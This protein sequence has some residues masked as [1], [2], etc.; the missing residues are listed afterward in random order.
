MLLD[1]KI[2]SYEDQVWVDIVLMDIGSIIFGRPW[3]YDHNVQIE[4]R[5][6]IHSFMF[7]G[8]RI[9][10]KPYMKNI[11]PSKLLNQP[12]DTLSAKKNPSKQVE[13]VPNKVMFAIVGKE[14]SEEDNSNVNYPLLQPLMNDYKDIFPD[15]LPSSLPPNREI[16]HAIDLVPGSPLPNL[17]HYRMSPQEHEELRRQV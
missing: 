10:L 14:L 4:G 12:K 2:L 9:V 6:N 7:K 3:L 1:V 8:K 11:H 17:P 16:Q 13:K 5:T 15:E